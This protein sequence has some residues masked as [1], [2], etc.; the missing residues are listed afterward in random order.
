MLA[1][2]TAVVTCY[3][4]KRSNLFSVTG[5]AGVMATAQAYKVYNL[6]FGGSAKML[7]PVGKKN[8]YTATLGVM[9]FS[10]RSG[11]I[12]EILNIPGISVPYNVAHPSLTLLTPKVGYKYF[13]TKKFNI[14]AEAGYCF[15][16]VKKIYDD[17]PGSVGGYDCSLGVSWLVSKK[18]DFGLRYELF[19]STASETNYTAFVAARCLINL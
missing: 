16:F 8:Y 14:E 12:S 17:Y 13:T 10:G 5:E 6:G 4:Q 1:C 19:E 2:I 9:A 15:A 7:F 11:K 18:L 3:S